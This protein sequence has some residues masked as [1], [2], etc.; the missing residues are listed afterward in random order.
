MGVRAHVVF[1]GLVQ[2]VYFRANCRQDALARRLT[3]WVQNRPD[4]TVE[5]VFEGEKDAVLVAIEWN[6]TS[7]PTAKVSRADVSWS[8]ATGEF[9]TF[10][11][12][13]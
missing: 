10:E 12:R 5:A 3:G 4:G 2:G 11:I 1:H 8:E 13:R 7:Q 9:P 6:R